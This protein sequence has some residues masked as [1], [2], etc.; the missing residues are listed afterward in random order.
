MNREAYTFEFGEFR[1]DPS[2]RLLLREGVPISVTPKV[3]DTLLALVEN[4]GHMLEKEELMRRVWPDVVVEEA[5]LAVNVSV[6]RKILGE[7]RGQQ[8]IE[9]VP[10]HGYRFAASV[11]RFAGESNAIVV[12][13]H[14]RSHLVIDE[15]VESGFEPNSI[16]SI[17]DSGRVTRIAVSGNTQRSLSSAK[18]IALFLLVGVSVG[19]YYFSTWSNS[20]DKTPAWISK[21]VAVLPFTRLTGEANDEYLGLAIADAL[22][23]RLGT[24][25]TIKVRPTSEIREFVDARRD[26][27]AIGR[28][29]GVDAVVDGNIQRDG[30]RVRVTVQLINLNDG[31][32]V[33]TETFDEKSLN[34][35]TLEDSI[36]QN[37]ARALAVKLSSEENSRLRKRYTENDEAYRAYLL[38]RYFFDRSGVTGAIEESIS[39]F[40]QAIKLDPRFARAYAGLADAYSLD[41]AFPS[42]PADRLAAHNRVQGA[43]LKALEIDNTLADAHT[44]LAR[45]RSYDWEWADAEK[46]YQRAIELDQENPT[47]RFLY[48]WYLVTLGRMDEGLAQLNHAL[49]LDPLS[50]NINITIGA[51]LTNMGQYDRAIEQL[52]KTSDLS[53]TSLWPHV[54]LA[55]AYELKG[56]IQEAVAEFQRAVNLNSNAK[57]KDVGSAEIRLG[58]TYAFSGNR[59][60]AMKIINKWNRG[61]KPVQQYYDMAVLYAG[62]GQREQAFELLEKVYQD[63]DMNLLYVRTDP[64][65]RGLR[66]D[67][68]Y[69]ELMRRVGL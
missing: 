57:T 7:S 63:K 29:L 51:C 16:N 48:G 14:T 68:R 8:Y 61:S 30:E 36:S 49:E 20:K 35:L 54:R 33:W 41:L 21:S 42:S 19:V 69:S 66:E 3:F 50:I 15:E 67:P 32:T 5:N 17:K 55:Q 39:Y 58:Q 56:D 52:R 28:K 11:R 24:I 18:L 26:P 4:S 13:E 1:L 62:L 31:S 46:E 25:R 64:R 65:L 47:A 22:I 53:P 37:V 23:T 38:G 2:E 59:L 34:V 10:K 27:L 44:S 60:A 43:V 40:Q 9:T 6:L 12:E 45:L